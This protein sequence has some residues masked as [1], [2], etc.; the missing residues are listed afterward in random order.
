MPPFQKQY[1][2]RRALHEWI[3]GKSFKREVSCFVAEGIGVIA[4][5]TQDCAGHVEFDFFS[6]WEALKAAPRMPKK[7][8]MYHTHPPSCN[9]MS[10]EDANSI[11]GWVT[12]LGIPI[13]MVVLPSVEIVRYLCLKGNVINELCGVEVKEFEWFLI[14]LLDG[15]SCSDHVCTQDELD[16]IVKETND[17]LL[18]LENCYF[19]TPANK[20]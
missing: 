5:S 11:K 13:E 1:D 4:I 9:Q 16:G 18:I 12:A 10:S 6:I 8:W 20:E 2:V 14:H 17:N 3:D 15:L 7:A 19:D